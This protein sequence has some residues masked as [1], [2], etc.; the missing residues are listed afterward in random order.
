MAEG[1]FAD[2]LLEAI[3]RKRSHVVVGLDPDLDS[4]P[5]LLRAKHGLEQV[6]AGAGGPASV[7]GVATPLPIPEPWSPATGSS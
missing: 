7:K 5:P 6:E 3:E 2:R 1:H 4:L